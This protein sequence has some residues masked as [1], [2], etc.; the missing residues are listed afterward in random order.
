MEC[1]IM[2]ESIRELLKDYPVVVPIT[3][4][5]GEMD[6][7]QHVNNIVYFRYFETARIA[8]FEKLD[9]MSM[10]QR[11]GVG[12]I[13]GETSCKF[14]KPL[15]YPDVVWAGARVATIEEDRFTMSLRLVSEKLET[16][17]AEGAAVIVAYDYHAKRKAE[18]PAL[19]RQHI[20]AVEGR[21][22]GA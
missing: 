10:T 1:L 12:P 2:K 18:L 13:L 5:W 6:A 7:L 17:A 21:R 8:Y 14:R 19:V 20:E 16:V 4:A 9:F 11:T 3:I 15:T 22:F